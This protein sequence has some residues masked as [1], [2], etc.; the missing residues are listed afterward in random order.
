MR[1]LVKLPVLLLVNLVLCL[2]SAAR[3]QITLPGFGQKNAGSKDQKANQLLHQNLPLVLDANTAYPTV[4]N[5]DLLGGPFRGRALPV[6]L[7]TLTKPLPPGDYV[8]PMMFFCSEYSIHRPG[9]GTAYVLAP[10]K[11]TAA[12]AISTLLWRGMLTGHKPQELQSVSWAIQGSVPYDKMPVNYKRLVDELIPDMKNQVNGQAFADIEDGFQGRVNKATKKVS[13]AISKGTGGHVHADIKIDVELNESFQRLGRIGRM[14][15]DG[16]NI[17]SIVTAA[18]PSDEARERALYAGQGTQEPPLPAANG[19]W[20]VI[21]PGTAYMRFVVHGGNLQGDNLMQIRILKPGNSTAALRTGPHFVLAQYPQ[22]FPAAP[23]VIGLVNGTVNQTSLNQCLATSTPQPMCIAGSVDVGGLAAFSVGTGAQSPL[24]TAANPV[25]P[26][27]PPTNRNLCV[28]KAIYEPAHI[29]AKDD[30]GNPVPNS[31][32]LCI[33]LAAV[34][35][36]NGSCGDSVTA[37]VASDQKLNWVQTYQTNIESSGCKT[38]TPHKDHCDVLDGQDVK[39]YGPLYRPDGDPMPSP[40][41]KN[42]LF[43][44]GFAFDNWKEAVKQQGDLQLLFRDLPNRSF[45]GTMKPAAVCRNTDEVSRP[46]CHFY[47]RTNAESPKEPTNYKN[48][49]PPPQGGYSKGLMDNNLRLVHYPANDTDLNHFDYTPMVQITYG[50]SVDRARGVLVVKPLIIGGRQA[51]G[52]G[53]ISLEHLNQLSGRPA[54][55]TNGTASVL[56]NPPLTFVP[57]PYDSH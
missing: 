12:K 11:G 55:C 19:P 21:V 40:E 54:A 8:L 30:K 22:N 31:F 48:P 10:A 42:D 45:T 18:Y 9:A 38:G 26:S 27:A 25:A 24:L 17:N 57:F 20:S 3:G 32:G 46:E 33:Y 44:G 29:N 6:T 50:F 56:E 37:P 23:S 15:L 34:A 39:E 1:V 52:G 4:A 13:D 28:K 51:D 41:G 2:T 49:P 5:E 43:V 35:D 53:T 14:A 47:F 7:D 36:V 16:E